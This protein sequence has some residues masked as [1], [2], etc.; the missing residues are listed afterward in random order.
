VARRDKWGD[1]SRTAEAVEVYDALDAA[2]YTPSWLESLVAA[3]RAVGVA[4]G[5]DTVELNDPAECAKLL[6]GPAD[7][8]AA[9]LSFIRRCLQ[10]WQAQRGEVAR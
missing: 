3:E 5:L 9:G 6:P 1:L 8:G 4:F 10:D 2:P 7:P